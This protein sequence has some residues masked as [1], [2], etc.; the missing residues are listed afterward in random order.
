[1]DNLVWEQERVDAWMEVDGNNTLR[2]DHPLDK[3]SVVF[4]VGGY[5]G[6]TSAKL[7]DKF[8]CNVHVFEPIPEYYVQLHERFKNNPKVHTYPFGLS[9]DSYPTLMSSDHYASGI[10]GAKRDTLVSM[11]GITSFM[12][13]MCIE[14]VNLIELNIE[15]GEYDL[16]QYMTT[17]PS[18]INR[19][20]NLQIQF[21]DV[22]KDGGR[23]MQ[24]L[25]KE[26]RK[27]HELT[28]QYIYCF[29]NWRRKDA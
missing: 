29:E 25:W 1:M 2:L 17:W 28:Y 8:G 18:I 16:L 7:F 4:D 24:L 23:Y 6:D 12:S 14:R 26:L 21:H 22:L 10:Y 19:F 13:E 11:V 9:F 27:T 3:D 20:D 5:T 15:G